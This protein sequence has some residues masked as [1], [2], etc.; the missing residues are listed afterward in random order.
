MQVP[1]D[2]QD[3]YLIEAEAF[4]SAIKT[5]KTDAIQSLHEDSAL[6]YQATQWITSASSEDRHQI[7]DPH[8]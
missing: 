2:D 6:S 4:I 8:T 3:M 7:A 5:G 1:L